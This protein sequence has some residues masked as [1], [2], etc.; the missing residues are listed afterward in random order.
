V[1]AAIE[2]VAEPQVEATGT[3]PP[4]RSFP[5]SLLAGRVIHDVANALGTIGGFSELLIAALPPRMPNR[6]TMREYL[7]WIGIATRDATRMISRYRDLRYGRTPSQP[8]ALLRIDQ[9][10]EQAISLTR[11]MWQEEARATGRT[12]RI[13][14]ELADLPPILGDATELR[15]VLTNLI[16]NAIDAIDRAGIITIRAERRGDDALLQIADTGVGMHEEIRLRSLEPFFTTK[17]ERGTGLGLAIVDQIVARHGGTMDIES[18][19]GEGTTVSLCFALATPEAEVEPSG[20]TT[21]TLS[22]L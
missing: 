14:T 2:H 1:R 12:I 4:P 20:Q 13:E 17:Q 15:E 22:A 8:F 16:H 6:D 9:L 3:L 11:P 21:L 5:P 10:V 7:E 18:T 19:L